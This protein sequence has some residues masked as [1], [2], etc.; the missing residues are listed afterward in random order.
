MPSNARTAVVDLHSHILQGIDDGAPDIEAAIALL[1]AE[2]ADGVNTVVLTPHF[3]IN[4]EDVREFLQKRDGAYK[5]LCEKAKDVNIKLKL[6]S[7]VM[8]SP[9]LLEA[10]L[11][12]FCIEGTKTLLVEFPFFHAPP[13][14][15]EVFYKLGMAGFTPLIA[16]VERYPY[17]MRETGIL[18]DLLRRGAYS[19]INA[20][21]FLHD[22]HTRKQALKLVENNLAHAVATDSHSLSDRPPALREAME[23]IAKKLG[24][25]T[26]LQLMENAENI[27]AG[28]PWMV[29]EPESI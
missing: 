26:V 24:R 22:S 23:V 11:R 15:R 29:P 5:S 9:D 28:T 6:A 27:A 16:H 12:P 3:N 20:G 10:D 14:I 21:S 17:F 2:A 7:E 18:A 19:Q 13:F 8:F 4:N 25:D 1:R